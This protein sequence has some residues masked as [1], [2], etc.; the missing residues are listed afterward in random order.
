M[1]NSAA[2]PLQETS[3]EGALGEE[4]ADDAVS[5]ATRANESVADKHHRALIVGLLKQRRVWR[6]H[7]CCDTLRD[8]WFYVCQVAHAMPIRMT[9][10]H[11]TIIA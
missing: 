1:E 7:G 11:T 2:E 4:D 10:S 9:Q 5:A 3:L 8:L 6:G